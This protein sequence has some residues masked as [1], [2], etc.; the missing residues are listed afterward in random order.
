MPTRGRPPLASDE[1]I[2]DRALAMFARYG[3]AAMSV[4]ALNAELGLS[5]E[6]VSARFGPKRDLYRATVGRGVALLMADFNQEFERCAP[7]SDVERLRATIRAF[8]VAAS[9]H[10]AI[11]DLL[12]HES[13][14]AEQ[15]SLLIG[16]TGL[17]ER[18]NGSV[19]LLRRLHEAGVIRETRIRELWFLVQGAVGP[20]Q[21]P[22]LSQMFD[23][24]DGPLNEEELIDRMTEAVT[25]SVMA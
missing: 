4:R 21:F 24:F 9:R 12:Y 7:T 11:G 16:Q 2:L 17:A 8:M 18:M 5:H 22:G 10:P 23:A 3:Y 6:T 20:I 15:R 19:D 1:E 13:I 25:R 14:D